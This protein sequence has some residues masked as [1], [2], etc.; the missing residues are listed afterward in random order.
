MDFSFDADTRE[1]VELTRDICTRHVTDASLAELDARFGPGAEFAGTDRATTRLH[2]ECWA[3]LTRSGVPAA[4]ADLA[5]GGAGLGIAGEVGVLRE[6]GRW[7]APVPLSTT[8]RGAD[9]LESAGETE[10]ARRTADGDVLVAVASGA[11]SD[12]GLLETEW[13]PAADHLL[14]HDGAEASAGYWSVDLREARAARTVEVERTVPVDFSSSGIV[15]FPGGPLGEQPGVTRL[16]ASPARHAFDA[17]RRRVHLAAYQWG[18]LEAALELTSTYACEREQFG[19]PIGTFQ[20]V[21]GRLADGFI[22]VDAVRLSTLRAAFELDRSGD[23]G[24]DH[25]ALSA[26]ASAHFWACEA[27]HRV[28]HSA[29]HVHGGVALDRDAPAHRY[30]LAAKACEF[31]L[32]GATIQ[33]LE[34]GSR[35]AEHGDAWAMS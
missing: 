31:R 35:L 5:V 11:G 19:R 24:P 26:V 34:L 21:A 27:G 16:D 10:L 9:L 4:L 20:A 32:G 13:A 7:L 25:A 6:L 22:D 12:D 1:L 33:L 8:V 17:A 18:V 30:Y 14:V 29:V 3:D 28:A 23:P 15:R 2:E